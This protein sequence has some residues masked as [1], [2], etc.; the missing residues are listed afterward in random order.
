M[1]DKKALVILKKYYL[2][3]HTDVKPSL[4]DLEAGIHTG[5][6]VPFSEITHDEM[7]SEI[8]R[9]SERISLAAAA[10]SFLYS[11]SSGDM[12]YR[13]ALSSLVWARSLPEHSSETTE[14]E[15]G[16]CVVC[17]CSHGLDSR[18]NV[19]WNEY[20]VFRYLPPTQYGKSP[21]FICAEYVLNDL[22]EFEKLPAVEPCEEDYHI[23]NELFAAV[24][25]M[26]PHNM[27][28]ALVSEIRRLKLINETGNAIHCLLATLSICGILESS[29][30]KGFLHG[31]TNSSDIGW[32]RDGLSFYPLFFWRGKDGINYDAVKEIFGS[33]SG[34]KLSPEKSVISQKKE[35]TDIN[36][37][38]D[39]KA[40]Q[41]Y[42][43]GVFFVNLTNEERHFLA[44]NDLNP[45]WDTAYLFSVTHFR[46]KRTVLFYE[47]NSIVKVI[48][49]EQSVDDD[50][51]AIWKHYSEYDTCLA[52]EDRKLLLPL[53]SRG[54]AKPITAANV[55]AVN[56][57]GCKVEVYLKKNE[58][59]IWAGNFRNCQE[60]AIGEEKRIRNIV[61]D[62]DF[63]EFMKY[64]IST[65]PKDYFER[66][67]EIRE[68]GHQTVQ[69][70]AGDI[71]RC[72]T[73]R[74]HYTYGIIIGKTRELEKWPE[75]PAMHSFRNLMAQPIIVRMYDFV[76]SNADMTADQLSKISLR[77]P[78][79]CTDEDIIWGTHK[80]V[81][82]KELEPDD[83]QFQ[84]HL[85]RQGR[86]QDETHPFTAE[87][88]TNLFSKLIP[89]DQR[90][91]VKA[92]TSLCIEWGFASI[93]VPWESV[94][95]EIKEFLSKGVYYNSG[96][97]IGISGEYCG[98]SLAEILHETPHNT[99]QYN[100]LLPE[101]RE[102][103]N[104]IMHALGLPDDCTYDE[105]V[106]KYGGISRQKYIELEKLRC[107]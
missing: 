2:P 47:G 86:N 80:I 39:S 70:K 36:R 83:V 98:K 50:G 56:P 43:D 105:F 58:S 30:Q 26:K 95:D 54:R 91:K 63:H 102:K 25:L 41:Y 69:F 60:I 96:T 65:C 33:F 78:M 75:L 42:T 49:E 11:L 97:Q 46:K 67:A 51:S 52:T 40:A 48:H 38:A 5:V 104:L 3:Y 6:I 22:R 106:I 66:I 53:T 84:I 71:F 61:S 10:K 99:I 28:T 85:A 89:E 68:M 29:E 15:L 20:G 1:Q 77:P 23:L 19:D 45:E 64:Y 101:N 24:G 34:D 21:D 90:K 12:R 14:H 100:L 31:F 37:K 93:E 81:A 35:E 88:F 72:Q 82:H 44:L 57:F 4:S 13:T 92:P 62:T 55:L 87:T 107:K 76:T 17:G 18:E 74:N 73:D 103:F 27:D 79:I 32:Y 7:V 94:P 16:A 59:T 9:L 8:K